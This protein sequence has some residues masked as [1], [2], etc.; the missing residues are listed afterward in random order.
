MPEDAV[1]AS[2]RIGIATAV[3]AGRFI[4]SVRRPGATLD[5]CAALSAVSRS[6][7]WW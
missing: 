5:R 6:A 1:G 3:R 2:L 4:V 7:A